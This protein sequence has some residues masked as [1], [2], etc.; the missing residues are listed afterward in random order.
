MGR[1]RSRPA[2]PSTP[3]C[4]H[5]ACPHCV[6]GV[7][8]VARFWHV[9][10]QGSRAGRLEGP[11]HLRRPQEV[12][13]L[14]QGAA[15]PIAFQR[16]HEPVQYGAAAGHEY[17]EMCLTRLCR[18]HGLASGF[19][20]SRLRLAL[21]LTLCWHLPLVLSSPSRRFKSRESRLVQSAVSI[22]ASA[23]NCREKLWNYF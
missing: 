19:C 12:H 18:L 3:A 10:L 22:S 9:G 16:G 5:R 4:V 13:A 1:G 14:G 2:P 20:S 11:R 17:V 8:G 21:V 15:D 23:R 7:L 6:Y